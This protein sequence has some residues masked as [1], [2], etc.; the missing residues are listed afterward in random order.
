MQDVVDATIWLSKHVAKSGRL[1]VAGS[2][3]GG[4]LALATAAH[5]ETPPLTAV[6]C[7]YGMLDPAAQRYV[8]PGQPL[9]S[10]VE[11]LD[12]VVK[13]V[14][15]AKERSTPIDGYS[16]AGDPATDTR[17]IWM[18]AM[19][20]A[21]IYP[22]IMTGIRGLSQQIDQSGTGVIPERFRFLFP[23]TFGLHAKILPPTALLH[24]DADAPVDP[25][26]SK[27]V[28]RNLQALGV[29]TLME[30]VPGQGH[31]FDARGLPEGVDIHRDHAASEFIPSLVRVFDFIER[32]V[33]DS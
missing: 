23:A 13:A 7:I 4:Y 28:A 27:K 5:P 24:G 9:E 17:Y 10:P 2:S 12:S 6:L 16:F 19:H 26:L 25:E 11:N 31:G 15:E 14:Y 21:G 30:V 33:R 32:L 22:D 29:E 18:K 1:V 3:A 8:R 20:E